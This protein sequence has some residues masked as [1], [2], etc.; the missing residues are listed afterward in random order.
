M[1]RPDIATLDNCIEDARRSGLD[2]DPGP[3][4]PVHYH[5]L[6]GRLQASRPKVP[7]LYVDTA[8]NPYGQTLQELG[9]NDFNDILVRDPERQREAGL[10]LDIAQAFLQR[11]DGFEPKAEP[12]FQEVVSDLYDGFLSAEDRG[13]ILP[14]DN[15]VLSPL[16]KFGNPQFGPYTWPVDATQ[17]FGMSVA[18]VNLPPANARQG[19]LAWP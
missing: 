7:K 16:V 10:M 19:L 3:D 8:F 5:S 9:E 17:S 12:A 15:E 11:G 4:D 14:P 13:G 1:S 18:I 6:R 2:Q